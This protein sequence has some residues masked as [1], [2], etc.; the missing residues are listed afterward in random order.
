MSNSQDDGI[1]YIGGIAVVV[2]GVS[3]L[4]KVLGKMFIQLGHTFEALMIM[5]G[6]F[7]KMSLVFGALVMWIAMIISVCVL[8]FVFAR[9]FIRIVKNEQ[10]IVAACEEIAK[11]KNAEYEDRFHAFYERV[12][13]KLIEASHDCNELASELRDTLKPI[14]EIRSLKKKESVI[15]SKQ[16]GGGTSSVGAD[17]SSESLNP[18]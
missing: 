12:E 15:P 16:A 8:A 14:E 7:L 2:I 13:R 9:N 4:S 17:L 1:L 6:S 18:Y 3:L 10:R 5:T 11:Q